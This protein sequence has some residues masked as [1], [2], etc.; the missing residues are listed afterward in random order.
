MNILDELILKIIIAIGIIILLFALAV[1]AVGGCTI[2][3][4]WA[5]LL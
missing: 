4:L 5:F 1:G 2:G 3:A